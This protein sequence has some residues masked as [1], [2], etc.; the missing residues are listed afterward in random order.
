MINWTNT[1]IIGAFILANSAVGYYF[2]KKQ[3]QTSE[4]FT[5][6]G[7]K[8][9][10]AFLSAV[11]IATWASSYTILACAETS[12]LNGISGTIWYAFAVAFPIL[13]YVFPMRLAKKIRQVIPE[14]HTVVEFISM[15][16][17]NKMQQLAL[18]VILLGSVVEIVAQIYGLAL[19][20]FPF[21]GIPINISIWIIGFAF[22]VYV[23]T[24]GQ[25][26]V[27]ITSFLL[28]IVICI[29]LLLTI[30]SGMSVVGS[31]AA[32]ATA[33]PATHHNFFQ[34]GLS[35]MINFF[36]AL[37]ALTLTEPVIWQQI[38][39]GKNDRVVETST[40]VMA[41]GWAPL[42][43]GG[44]VIGLMA[45]K[46][47]GVGKLAN[48]ASASVQFVNDALPSWIGVIFMIG[49][50]AVILSTAASYLSSAV[51]IAVVDI[52]KKYF[53]PNATSEQQLRFARWAT[54]VM[55][56]ASI[57]IASYARS[58]VELL[59]IQSTF[60][61]SILFPLIY[62][63]YVSKEKFTP[64]GA[65]IGTLVGLVAAMLVYA[66]KFTPF[67]WMG[68]DL[69]ATL[70]ALFLSVIFSLIVSIMECSSGKSIGQKIS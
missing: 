39:S 1:I 64:N 23:S 42:A 43:L 21:L 3:T 55:G 30:F 70:S 61:V 47:Y 53:R 5:V 18:I 8:M 59:V 65:F 54:V 68:F 19:V 63:L 67:S 51:S 26:S 36:L 10:T 4:D 22:I 35:S 34:W 16:F 41:L 44:G 31:P 17:D 24:G 12:Y 66:T 20:F 33:L 37:T 6:G 40:K 60:K 56:V 7:R 9:G 62:G 50:T 58:M 46:Y 14:G 32:I 57:L 38:F 27:A 13:F 48:P 69:F 2:G 49:L 45:A 15:R 11:L 25:W 28:L 29:S 52:L